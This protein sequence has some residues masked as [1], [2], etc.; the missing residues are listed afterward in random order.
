MISYYEIIGLGWLLELGY[1]EYLVYIY[2]LDMFILF[3]YILMLYFNFIIILYD[4]LLKERC[5]KC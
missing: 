5:L 4:I 1:N 3:E 2:L